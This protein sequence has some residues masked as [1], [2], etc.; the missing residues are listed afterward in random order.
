ML[1]LS[2]AKLTIWN[3]VLIFFTF[4]D[5]RQVLSTYHFSIFGIDVEDLISTEG[6]CLVGPPP[7]FYTLNTE[8]M[9]TSQLPE[10]IH[11]ASKANNAFSE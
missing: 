8:Y 10:I 4:Y 11:V 1:D 2:P 5:R 6:T 7:F 9:S 3:E